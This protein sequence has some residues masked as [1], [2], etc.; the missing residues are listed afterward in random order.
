MNDNGI[1]FR[2]PKRGQQRDYV[3]EQLIKNDEY[4]LKQIAH[5]EQEIE[6]LKPLNQ[7]VQK[8]DAAAETISILYRRLK[9]RK[10]N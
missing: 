3:L 4:L 2:S 7:W 8:L 6:R 5:L 9:W 1:T 10:K